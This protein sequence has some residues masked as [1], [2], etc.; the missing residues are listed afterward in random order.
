MSFTTNTTVNSGPLII[1][2][3]LDESLNNTYVVGQYDVPI[4][5][6]YVLVTSNNGLLVPSRDLH[7]NTIVVD[8]TL[9][10]SICRTTSLSTITV[11]TTSVSTVSISS[12]LVSTHMV[13]CSSL[14]TSTITTSTLYSNGFTLENGSLRYT[15]LTKEVSSGMIYS[16][17]STD[18]WGKY[19]FVTNPSND[20]SLSLPLSGIVPPDGTFM[21]ITNAAVGYTTTINN[22]ISGDRVLAYPNSAHVIYQSSLNRWFSLS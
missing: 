20:V 10:A 11:S 6:N 1:R 22:L 9:T 5:N 17:N 15:V 21:Y 2:T 12:N 7:L 8:S 3:V 4:A 16:L 19:I 18:W 14:Q 13:S